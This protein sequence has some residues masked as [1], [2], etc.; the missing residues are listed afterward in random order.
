MTIGKDNTRI[1]LT[2]PKDLHSQIKSAAE[3]EGRSANNWI[4]QAIKTKLE[5]K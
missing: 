4:I 5:A 2:I 1:P 3:A